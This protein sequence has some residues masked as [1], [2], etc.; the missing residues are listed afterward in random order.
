MTQPGHDGTVYRAQA[1]G[2]IPAQATDDRGEPPPAR[3]RV[4]IIGPGQAA[5]APSVPAPATPSTDA[6]AAAEPDLWSTRATTSRG[7]IGRPASRAA[8]DTAAAGATAAAPVGLATGTIPDVATRATEVVPDPPRSG[9][10][11]GRPQADRTGKVLSGRMARLHIGWHSASMGAVSMV[12]VPGAG[13]GLVVGTD[14]SGRAVPVRFFRPEPT[15]ITLLGGDWATVVL[16]FRALALGANVSVWTDDPHRWRGLGE[17]AAGPNH[18]VVNAERVTLPAATP[19]QPV[20]S[21][22][23]DGS[24]GPLDASERRAWQTEL[25]VLRRLDERG[26]AAIQD[27]DLVIAQRLGDGEAALVA[28]ALRL[29]GFVTDPLQQ[30]DDETVALLGRSDPRYVRIT[31]TDIERGLVGSA[32]R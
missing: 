27:S 2:Q 30:I 9:T 20:L 31:A 26:V 7:M 12:H 8:L 10:V 11:Y 23:D 24:G 1:E 21:V 5:T 3:P 6:P 32:R 18:F 16:V 15:R 28:S 13:T 17:R 29:P 25:T 19:Q 14:H 4:T 22:T